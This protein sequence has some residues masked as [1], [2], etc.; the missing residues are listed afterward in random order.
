MIKLDGVA[1]DFVSRRGTHH[2]LEKVD[3]TIDDGQFVCLVGPSGCGK[4]TLLNL[5]AGLE[6]ADRGGVFLDGKPITAPG[7]D[8]SVMFQDS[9]LFPW[10]TVQRNVEFGLEARRAGLVP[11]GRRASSCI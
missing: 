5:V 9:A 10:L 3:L 8:R 7:P 4:S 2:A 1:K 11:T 6:R